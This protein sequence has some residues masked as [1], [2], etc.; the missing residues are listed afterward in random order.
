MSW[1]FTYLS[2]KV[3][4]PRIPLKNLRHTSATVGLGSGETLKEISE[5]LGH[6]TEVTTLDHPRA[7]DHY[8]NTKPLVGLVDL[9]YHHTNQAMVVEGPE[10][11]VRPVAARH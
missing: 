3:G 2:R 4:L 11:V 8:G 7:N 5:R 1:R 10:I 9:T 6:S